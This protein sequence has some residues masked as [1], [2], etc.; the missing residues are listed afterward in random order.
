MKIDRRRL[1]KGSLA[2]PLVMTVR[3]ASAAANGSAVACLRRSET[4]AH[5]D[6][7][8]RATPAGRRDEWVRIDIDLSRLAPEQGKPFYDGKY[9][10]GFDQHTYWRLDDRRPFHGEARPT[11]YTR[12]SCYEQ[13]TGERM[14]ALAFIDARGNVVDFGWAKQPRGTPVMTSCYTSLTAMKQRV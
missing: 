14:Q 3:P 10:L 5:A 12:G 1:L 2:A 13:K 8:D 11:R 7:P 6:P 9:F 4:A